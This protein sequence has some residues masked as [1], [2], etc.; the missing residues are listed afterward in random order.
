[1]ALSVAGREGHGRSQP[2][3]LSIA[4]SDSG[5]GAGVQADLKTFFA[6]GVHGTCAITSVTS[7]NT[8][9]VVSRF[10]LP[11]EVVVSQVEAVVS[12]LEP[13]AVKT[14]MLGTAEVVMAVARMA[15]EH[16]WERLVVDPVVRSSSGHP[17]L[18]ESGRELLLEELLPRGLV[19]TPNLEEA[20]LFT[21]VEVRELG[22]MR[23]AARILHER[24]ARTVVVKGGHLRGEEAVDVFFDGRDYHE[25]RAPRVDTLDD[26]GTGCVFSAALV[27]YLAR[28]RDVLEAV[29]GARE[30]VS[31]A[32]AH[33]LRLGGGRGPVNPVPAGGE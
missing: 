5:G 6:L 31:L 2:V 25:M 21:G 27:A 26:H 4:G 32:L 8:L 17:L 20:A 22:G 11:A 19:F 18:E 7:Q 23:K 12:D 3:V 29:R 9:G 16:G 13:A 1:M 14:G 33:S 30:F 15:E 28:G 10:D 24:G